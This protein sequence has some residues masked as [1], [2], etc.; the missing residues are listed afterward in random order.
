MSPLTYQLASTSLSP[1]SSVKWWNLAFVSGLV[2]ISTGFLSVGIYLSVIFQSSTAS[3]MKWYQMSICLVHVWNLLSFDNT[4]APWLSQLIVIGL[5]NP[6]IS[7]TNVC[8]YITSFTAWVCAMYS[9]SV[10]DNTTIYC[11]LE[12]QVTAPAPIWNE[13]LEIECLCGCP[14]QSASQN[15]SR[16]VLPYPPKVS[17]RF[18]VFLRYMIILF[19]PSQW[20]GP[21]FWMN[22]DR[23]PTA[24][25]ASGCEITTG[26][27][28]HL[29]ACAYGMSHI[30]NSCVGVDGLWSL[31]NVIPG[32][33]GVLTCFAL[34][35]WNFS[36]ILSI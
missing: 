16:I 11:F 15:P 26:H 31:L 23:I 3:W 1:N 22:W 24:N 25:A 18:F 8:K 32:S 29:I 33:I 13:Y 21:G 27:R 12:L 30:R 34:V 10:L 5:T 35:S 17:Q 9:A 20:A 7:W 14:A 4:I 36:T 19:T 28:R 2:N 6:R